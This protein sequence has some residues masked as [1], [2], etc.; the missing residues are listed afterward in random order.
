MFEVI[1]AG[2]TCKDPTYP[3][4]IE[5]ALIFGIDRSSIAIS[6]GASESFDSKTWSDLL[7]KKFT[8]DSL[9]NASWLDSAQAE[10]LNKYDLSNL[11]WSKQSSF[12]RGS[13]AAILGIQEVKTGLIRISAIGDCQLFIVD[14]REE[15]KF[16]Y[17][18]IFSSEFSNRP[19]LLST[20]KELNPH[21]KGFSSIQININNDD[22][23][24][25]MSDAL[26]CW[27]MQ[28]DERQD[29]TWKQVLDISSQEELNNLVATLRAQKLIK[30]DDVTLVVAQSV[31][32]FEY[33]LSNTRAI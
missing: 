26:A 5:D 31:E 19:K 25:M 33:E 10:Y 17:P 28:S 7:V 12:E 24:L 22:R 13:F 9:I 20:K 14:S 30:V 6:D 16:C 2:Q 21:M 8:D 4:S 23:I 27:F 1:F 18:Y 15:I 32:D 3:E 29:K 11:S